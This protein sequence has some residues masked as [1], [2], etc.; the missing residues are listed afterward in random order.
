MRIYLTTQRLVLREFVAADVDNLVDLDSDAEVMHFI[1]GGLPTARDEVERDILPTWIASYAHSSHLG[2]S[3]AE[4]KATGRFIGWFHLRPGEG[5]GPDQPELGYRLRRSAWGNGY[6]TEGCRAL[7]DKAFTEL[8]ASRVLAETMVV[9]AA[10]T[11][12]VGESRAARRAALPRRLAAPDPRRRARRRQVRPGPGRVGTPARQ[13]RRSEP[14]VMK[15]VVDQDRPR[16]QRPTSRDTMWDRRRTR[17][18][19]SAAACRPSRAQRTRRRERDHA[20]GVSRRHVRCH[21][22]PARW[23]ARRSGSTALGS[24]ATGRSGCRG[25]AAAGRRRA[26][27]TPGTRPWG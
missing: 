9:H 12:G 16:R 23:L 18:R 5:H 21:E 22:P 7:I 14:H 10:S 1:T 17:R 6:A 3:A 8:G 13:R 4:E 19:R 11:P 2:F 15:R 25:T 24:T 27:P 20:L 26:A